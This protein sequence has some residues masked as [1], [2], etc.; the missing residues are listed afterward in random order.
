M[1]HIQDQERLRDRA[2][3]VALDATLNGIKLLFV[4]LQ[5]EAAPTHALVDV[6]FL[7]ANQLAK[8]HAD[9]T[10]G[11]LQL[12]EVF[13]ITGGSRL[14]GGADEGEVRVTAITGQ[15]T[16]EN[17]QLRIE[18][19][20]DYSTY[21]LRVTFRDPAN[22]NQDVFDPIFSA[23]DFKFRPGCFNLDY[24][25]E[26]KPAAAPQPEPAIDYLAKD[27][28]SFKH[29]LINA[30]A[31]RVPNWAPTSEADLDQVL[32]D[33][34]AADAD[35]LSD[36]Q[37]R[38][39]NEAFL[40][41]ARKRVSLVRHARL[42]DYQV[43]PG[44]QATTWL[45][46]K[47]DA[48]V[49]LQPW[50]SHTGFGV[51][52]GDATVG[53]EAVMDPDAVIF[54]NT[55]R[56]SCF[57]LLNELKPYTWGGLVTALE[58]GATQVDLALPAPASEANANRIR[59]LFLD[60][61]VTHLLI[62]Q[63]LNPETGTVNGRD[64][65]ARQIVSL[66][67]DDDRSESERKPRAESLFDPKDKQWFVRVYWLERDRLTRRYCFVTT[68]PK[69]G[70]ILDVSLFHA[71]LLRV[72]H[73]RPYK[74]TFAAPEKVL[75][76]VVNDQFLRQDNAHHESTLTIQ[77]DEGPAWGSICRLPN[78]PLAHCDKVVGRQ[79]W[80]PAALRVEVD[81]QPWYQR[82]DLI[83]SEKDARHFIVETDEHNISQI[84]FG[85]NR[86]GRAL[87]ADAEVVCLYQ[88]G[89]GE[90]GNVGADRLTGFDHSV[91]P[92]VTEA[93]N[94][95]DVTNGRSPEPPERIIRRASEAYRNHQLRAVTLEDY[96]ERAE[97][98]EGVA[99]AAARYVWT[100]SWRG[101]RVVIDPSGTTAM[102]DQLRDRVA[103]HLDAVRLI[104]DDI[105][106]RMAHY[107]P[108]MIEL[109]LCAHPDYWPEDLDAALRIEFSD[110]HT[111]DGRLAFFHP[112]RWT[113]GQPLYVSQIVGR[114]LAVTG[115]ERLVEV[116]M[117]RVNPRPG[118]SQISVVVSPEDLPSVHTER[119]EVGEFEIVQVANDP[120]RLEGGRIEFDV[121]GGRA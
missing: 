33:L 30:M 46:V 38:V 6:E 26:W 97:E 105:E 118:P 8:I 1:N 113:F 117:R 4:K 107:V 66:G 63:K 14:V 16:P 12:D 31:D 19:I 32:I 106:L 62:E 120:S 98:L 91:H 76:A 27:F 83:D 42:M 64:V 9:V 13:S 41:S 90:S 92:H 112:D 109:R 68:C 101:V 37:D 121:L 85:N 39:M 78:S 81:G 56:R 36:Y 55:S 103:R 93:W 57:A 75:S 22:P 59:D 74:T 77:T 102:S 67:R 28:A 104:G 29:V 87:T 47:V 15:P 89:Q 49:D 24:A 61:R 3:E 50:H 69:R 11:V 114:A 65:T 43:N 52:T 35:E 18:P 20:G 119:V 5:P 54:A 73:G 34:I 53:E 17:L 70:E 86:N 48:D 115:V 58:T 21:R 10:A 72:A 23:I 96:I 94:P 80:V 116:R 99:H 79:Q 2:R 40:T 71:N 25:P 88:V 100:G 110:G 51:W 82:N 95:L 84:R 108:L 60:E 45:A 111:P 44:N 7:N